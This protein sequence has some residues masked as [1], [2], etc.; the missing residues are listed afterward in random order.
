MAKRSWFIGICARTAARGNT[1][2]ANDWQWLFG[3]PFL[4]VA[5]AALGWW[6][7]DAVTFA[8][9]TIGTLGA[10]SAAFLLTWVVAFGGR[11]IRAPAKLFWG[12]KDERDALAERLT[13]KVSVYF[14]PA[15]QGTECVHHPP[16]APHD[17]AV[18]VVV[19][20]N[21]DAPL[22]GCRALLERVAFRRL[23]QTD[24]D[25]VQWLH[26]S[27][28]P[29]SWSGDLELVPEK[30][31]KRRIDPRIRTPIDVLYS[32]WP[33]G[34]IPNHPTIPPVPYLKACSPQWATE[35][36]AES[37]VYLFTVYVSWDGPGWMRITL[38]SVWKGEPQ[39]ISVTQESIESSMPQVP[40]NSS[41]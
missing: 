27:P 11:F 15:E 6:W 13:P 16:E 20:L 40:A 2:F 37:G 10:A 19:I 7:G 21:S 1:P 22:D 38:R 24:N 28:C 8:E 31:G 9:G 29:L 4:A 35:W 14:T 12:M 30:F 33:P 5:L 34:W 32:G 23:D 18:R 3:F 17:T 39:R 41:G 36:C 25:F 26:Y